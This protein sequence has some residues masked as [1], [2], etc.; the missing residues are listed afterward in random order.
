MYKSC[1]EELKMKVLKQYNQ[2]QQVKNLM[3]QNP[4]Y[5]H[6]LSYTKE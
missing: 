4:L 2:G 5:I 3:Y 6:G 1:K